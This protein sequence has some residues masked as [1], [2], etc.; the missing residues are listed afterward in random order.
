M[1][2][3]ILI[4]LFP[5]FIAT[6]CCWQ[7]LPESLF[8]YFI[9]YGIFLHRYLYFVMCSV[10]GGL[11]TF[12]LSYIFL[13]R[14]EYQDFGLKAAIEEATGFLAFAYINLLIETWCLTQKWKPVLCQAIQN[15]LF[16]MIRTC[17]AG[18]P[19]PGRKSFRELEYCFLFPAGRLLTGV[20]FRSL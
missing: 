14:E 2:G 9:T 20:D 15:I 6:C 13:K 4:P 5:E 19:G 8:I 3:F 1:E 10:K 18:G 12:M 16:K 17:L 11:I 7:L